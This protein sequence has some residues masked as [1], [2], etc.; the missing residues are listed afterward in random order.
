[1]Y[2]G[3]RAVGVFT[4][5]IGG[6]VGIT[7]KWIFPII[8][9]LL[10]AVIA[11]A[12][13]KL[14]FVPDQTEESSPAV[15]TGEVTEP[16]IPVGLGTI[17]NDVIITATVSADPAV[18]VKSTAAGTVS[19]LFVEQGAPVAAGDPIFEVKVPIER[20]PA[21]SV[22]AEGNPLPAIFRYERVTAPA[23]GVLSSLAVIR[24]QDV[25]IGMAAGQVA[26]PT[27]SVSGSLQPEQQ[28]RL[29]DQ[30]TEAT[31][32]I[33]GGPAPFV[34]TGLRI[35]TPL[36]GSTGDGGGSA[37]DAGATGG[38]GAS[39]GATVSCAVPAEVTVFSGLAAEMTLAGGR[40]ENVLVVPT[41]AVRGAAQSGTV[42][43]S[44]A[45]GGTEERA[46][47]LGLG[48]GSQI[49]VTDGL[50]EGEEILQFAPGAQAVT[51]DDGC[52][53][54]PDGNMVCAEPVQMP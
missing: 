50:T 2:R 39:T 22:D 44:T 10:V 27:F 32:A 11:I 20:D 14:A 24:G 49:E 29:L 51:G 25:T 47:A 5:V 18:P 43:V 3:L 52:T 26:P 4:S 21:K 19:K 15:P 35:T 31:V 45:D 23:A 7:R 40:A 30:P 8:R 33:T 16:R 1:M 53:T 9:I 34:C 13:A 46:V 37:P 12:L 36:A 48:D 17:T 42:W 54:M 28:Y 6:F 38:S 41:T